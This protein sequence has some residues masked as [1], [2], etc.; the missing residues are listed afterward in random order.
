LL[1]TVP[2]ARRHGSRA[3]RTDCWCSSQLQGKNGL[4]FEHNG[5]MHFDVP[6]E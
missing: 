1:Q 3:P 5:A 2:S 6:L 4:V